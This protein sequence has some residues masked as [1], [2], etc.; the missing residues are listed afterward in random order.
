VPV[1]LRGAERSPRRSI[2]VLVAC[3]TLLG[4]CGGQGAGDPAPI[5]ST[6]VPIAATDARGVDVVATTLPP[7]VPA[8]PLAPLHAPDVA[9]PPPDPFAPPVSPPPVPPSPTSTGVP[10]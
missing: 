1:L 2:V 9:A 4:A 10:L 8:D 3:G 6:G 5:P 7:M